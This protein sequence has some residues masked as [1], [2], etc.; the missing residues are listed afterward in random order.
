MHQQLPHLLTSTVATRVSLR[1]HSM[2]WV[3][4]AG[5]TSLAHTGHLTRQLK[6]MS[7]LL[8][9]RVL[10]THRTSYPLSLKT[11]HSKLSTRSTSLILASRTTIKPKQPTR[12][13]NHTLSSSNEK[14]AWERVLESR[15]GSSCLKCRRRL[16]LGWRTGSVIQRV[17]VRSIFWETRPRVREIAQ[18]Q[19]RQ[20]PMKTRTT[21][22]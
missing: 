16:E 8:S 9:N 20:K 1:P 18:R 2:F 17:S 21:G 4:L 5:T 14:A 19:G 6:L 15:H 10:R 22:R 7:F 12:F 13:S 11:Q 3:L